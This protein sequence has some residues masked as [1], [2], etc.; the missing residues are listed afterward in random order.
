[1]SLTIDDLNL[2]DSTL[3]FLRKR[4]YGIDTLAENRDNLE[5]LDGIGPGRARQIETALIEAVDGV[6]PVAVEQAAEEAQEA[7]VQEGGGEEAPAPFAD[8]KPPELVR[9]VDS[10]GTQMMARVCANPEPG[11]LH[12]QVFTGA[13]GSH[14]VESVPRGSE[15]PQPGTWFP[16]EAA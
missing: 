6:A 2:T 5:A 13:G 9:F 10:A 14:R 3:G 1:M 8:P 11:V 7:P 4:G 12:L 16:L 15:W